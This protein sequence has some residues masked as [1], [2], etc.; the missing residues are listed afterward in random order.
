M[1]FTK[2]KIFFSQA[3]LHI[4]QLFLNRIFY[5]NIFIKNSNIQIAKLFEE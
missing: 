2:K 1:F 4:I 5:K 3:I